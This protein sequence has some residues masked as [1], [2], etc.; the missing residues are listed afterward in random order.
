MRVSV[1]DLCRCGQQHIV[2]SKIAEAMYVKEYVFNSFPAQVRAFDGATVLDP[3]PGFYTDPVATLDFTSLYPSIMIGNNICTSTLVFPETA[4]EY[5]IVY[6]RN[7][8]ISSVGGANGNSFGGNGNSFGGNGNS[9]GGNGNSFGGNGNSFGGNGGNGQNLSCSSSAAF[10]RTAVTP[11]KRL[12][13]KLLTVTFDDEHMPTFVQRAPPPTGAAA[14]TVNNN[15]YGLVPEILEEML[16][17][18]K[19]VKKLMGSASGLVRTIYNMRQ[20]ALKVA[21]NS[22]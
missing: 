6:S 19:A 1:K 11:L 15:N 9:F 5:G 7:D 20:L 4:A 13:V 2:M 3:L 22:T 10:S 8:S 18:R 16:N 21:C 14:N 17:A 12:H